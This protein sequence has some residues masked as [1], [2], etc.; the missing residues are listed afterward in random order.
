MTLGVWSLHQ[1]CGSAIFP[2]EIRNFEFCMNTHRHSCW[3]SSNIWFLHDRN[4]NIINIINIINIMVKKVVSCWFDS[5]ARHFWVTRRLYALLVRP[6]YS[7]LAIRWDRVHLIL[8]LISKLYWIAIVY[9]VCANDLWKVDQDYL[10]LPSLTF[11][12][13]LLKAHFKIGSILICFVII[14]Q[15]HL[16]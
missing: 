15:S 12:F 5:F 2:G 6:I 16:N 10:P 13:L 8:L 7:A 11:S 1:I 4:V 3:F 14:Q 9:G